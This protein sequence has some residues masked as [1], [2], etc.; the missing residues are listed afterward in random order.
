MSRIRIL[1]TCFLAAVLL[2]GGGCSTNERIPADTPLTEV[3][4]A[5]PL[6][7]LTGRV[8]DEAELLTPDQE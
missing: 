7:A 5:R 6:P 4:G 1:A 8:V 2:A 3:A